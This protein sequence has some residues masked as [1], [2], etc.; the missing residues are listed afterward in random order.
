MDVGREYRSG[1]TIRRKSAT[2]S[3]RHRSVEG[4]GCTGARP[5]VRALPR[6]LASVA[7]P[8]GSA[9]VVRIDGEAGGTW[10]LVH[11]VAG[12]TLFGVADSPAC[13]VTLDADAAWR[14][15]FNG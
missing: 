3:A 14:L 15:F 10:S 5:L 13:R 8:P 4:D 1:G 2:P 9:L 7:R 11:D 12:W 6:S